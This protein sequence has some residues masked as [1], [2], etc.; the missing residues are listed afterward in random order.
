[1]STAAG[2]ADEELPVAAPES[3]PVAVDAIRTV[4]GV[5]MARVTYFVV[6]SEVPAP[7]WLIRPRFASEFSV[8]V[9][10]LTGV[11][12][13]PGPGIP[14][15]S[16]PDQIAALF[17]EVEASLELSVEVEDLWIP[18]DWLAH[19]HEPARG[20]V[21]RVRLPL[22]QAAYRFRTEGLSQEG[23]VGGTAWEGSTS[24]SPE[25]TAAFRAW[26]EAR[27]EEARSI[28]PKDERLVLGYW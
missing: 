5:E 11:I 23:F 17:E 24:Y 2:G 26:A 16:H 19:D 8:E 28:Y 20:D 15:F 3:V 9:L 10:G 25:E 13:G 14:R 12:C 22:F 7:T 27:I 21:Y 6:A 18:L 1:M 4:G